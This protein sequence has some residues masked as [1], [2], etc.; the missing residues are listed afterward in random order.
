MSAKKEMNRTT[1]NEL[2]R[3]IVNDRVYKKREYG[4]IVQDDELK[5]SEFPMFL[6]MFWNVGG[7]TDGN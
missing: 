7:E 2:N 6:W 5:Q 3:M 4:N 1:K